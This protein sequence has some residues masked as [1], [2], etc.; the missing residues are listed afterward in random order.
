M[1][2]TNAHINKYFRYLSEIS[3]IKIKVTDLT[4]TIQQCSQ[5]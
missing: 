1:N 5:L 4:L 3:G 2:I